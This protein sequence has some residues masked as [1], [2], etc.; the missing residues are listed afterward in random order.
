[1]ALITEGRETEGLRAD[2]SRFGEWILRPV[3]E[4]HS[5]GNHLPWARVAK[6]PLWFKCIV[7]AEVGTRGPRVRWLGIG[8]AS[9]SSLPPKRI[10]KDISF[11]HSP[12]M[13]AASVSFQLESGYFLPLTLLADNASG[14]VP[15]RHATSL[16]SPARA[17]VDRDILNAITPMIIAPGRRDP[18]WRRRSYTK[19]PSHWDFVLRPRE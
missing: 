3:I 8:R 11:S 1:M 9:R 17:K 13:A 4:R 14:R 12:S 15:S 6:L 16:P 5:S 10:S 2:I 19:G 18:P 7:P